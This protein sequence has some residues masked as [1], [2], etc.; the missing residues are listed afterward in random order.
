[1]AQVRLEDRAHQYAKVGLRGYWHFLFANV[2][3]ATDR[4]G[5]SAWQATAQ[6]RL[7]ALGLQLRH[8]ELHGFDSEAFFSPLGALRSRTAL[9]F[10][11]AIPESWL[12]RIPC[13]CSSSRTGSNPASGP[14]T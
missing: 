9:R 1:V 13:C 6:S 3:V 5:G 8:A 14:A 7:G 2:D 4:G 12:P 10:D 11:G